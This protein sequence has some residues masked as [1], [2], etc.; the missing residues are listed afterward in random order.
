MGEEYVTWMKRISNNSKRFTDKYPENFFWLG[1]IKLILPKSKIIHCYR[2]SKDNCLS[3]FK[4]HFPTGKMDYTYKLSN[5]VEY[6]NLY[7]E[8]MNHWLE[9]LPNFTFDIK[10]ENLIINTESEI[11]KL[12]E[13]CKLSW[14]NKCL[15]FHD[16]KRIVKTA[17]D[18][19]ARN[20]IYTSS[21]DSWKNYEKYLKEDF[22]KLKY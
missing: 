8:L 17:S 16:N 2:N 11:R 22:A 20:K 1:F 19:Q 18:V 14:N 5:I 7:Y 10:Y 6:Y 13:F 15:N 4:N 12:L 3:L 9:V 21:V